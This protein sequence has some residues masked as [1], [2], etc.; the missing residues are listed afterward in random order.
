VAAAEVAL[1]AMAEPII[2]L[3]FGGAGGGKIE[4]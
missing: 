3:H 2:D 4:L 1:L